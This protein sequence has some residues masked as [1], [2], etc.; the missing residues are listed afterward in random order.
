MAILPTDTPTDADPAADWIIALCAAF[1]YV[2][3]ALGRIAFELMVG[4]LLLAILIA[5]INVPYRLR[6]TFDNMEES[7]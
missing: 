1:A 4:M 5:L 2:T 6:Y 3:Y 7:E